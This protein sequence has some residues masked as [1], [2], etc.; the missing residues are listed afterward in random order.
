MAITDVRWTTAEDELSGSVGGLGAST[1]ELGAVEVY[2][3]EFNE[4]DDPRIR[5]FMAF[6]GTG[7]GGEIQIPP[8][9]SSHIFEPFIFVQDK[10]VEVLGPFHFKVIVIYGSVGNPLNLLSII[11][12]GGTGENTP[13]DRTFADTRLN[14]PVVPII[15][16]SDE[17]FDPPI[18]TTISDGVI[19][20]VRNEASYDAAL[21]DTFRDSTNDRQW[22]GFAL[23]TV[24]LP[25]IS[26][27]RKEAQLG[28]FYHEV[29]YVLHTR[30][31][32][33]KLKVLDQGFRTVKLDSENNPV[34][35]AN[36]APQYI[37]IV[38]DKGK[39]MTQPTLLKDGQKL[40]EA[41]RNENGATKLEFL[42]NKRQDFNDLGLPTV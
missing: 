9:R 40:T 17:L 4:A 20:I 36:G 35:D 15:N 3:V 2:H 32:G 12:Y 13:I 41:E 7:W 28:F 10:Q 23:E 27:V 6:F 21:M 24:K 14:I 16:S 42:I 19:T 25:V 38:D 37:E 8:M 11:T 22:Q 26:A 34:L 5:K 18:T 29:T 30:R 1:D 33:W 31:D 39:V